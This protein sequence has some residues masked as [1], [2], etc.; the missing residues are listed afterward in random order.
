[1]KTLLLVLL[2]AFLAVGQEK[3][4]EAPAKGQLPPEVQ[5]SAVNEQFE[6]QRALGDIGGSPAE[7]IH[8]LEDHLKKFPNS[9]RR[10]ELERAIF[11]AAL[12]TKDNE[13]I[14]TYGEKLVA[15]DQPDLETMDRYCRALLATESKENA[16]KA[17]AVVKRL[18][19][20]L[21][22]NDANATADPGKMFQS[23][24]QHAKFRDEMDR[25][26]GRALLTEATANGILGKLP[27]A[28]DLS[29]R[30]YKQY[31]TVEAAHEVARWLMAADKPQEALEHL[32]DAFT[33]T[34]S[35]NAADRASDRRKLGEIYTKLKGNETGLGDVL[36]QSYDRISAAAQRRRELLHSIDPNADLTSP[37]EYTLTGLKGEK[38]KLSSLKG[39]VVVLDFWA[40]WCGPCRAQQPLYE[41]VKERFKDRGDVIFLAINT[42]EDR[43]VVEPF[44]KAQNWNKNVYFEDGLSNLLRVSSIPTTIIFGRRGDVATRMNG[45]VP[46]RFVEMLSERIEVALGSGPGD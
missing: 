15:G 45:Y 12:E 46:E 35:R 16:T 22:T 43:E 42:D 27:E 36:L 44:L 23:A 34:D 1:M 5:Q 6:L 21:A 10:G 8:V 41:Q 17:L 3:K 14:V 28:I 9:A 7:F 2:V 30:A 33:L 38:L 39:K 13:R 25:S 11:K 31:P 32:A 37:L 4:K 40:T 20:R 26:L 18:E 24:R 29:K 19:E